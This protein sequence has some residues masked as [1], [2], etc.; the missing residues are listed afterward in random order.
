MGIWGT[1]FVRLVDPDRCN[2][3]FIP[4]T[5]VFVTYWITCTDTQAGLGLHQ[6][7]GSGVNCHLQEMKGLGMVFYQ[8]WGEVAFMLS[9]G[10]EK[11]KS[12]QPQDKERQSENTTM[13]NTGLAKD[14]GR[15]GV[16]TMQLRFGCLSKL[17][18]TGSC[19]ALEKRVAGLGDFSLKGYTG[20]CRYL[21]SSVLFYKKIQQYIYT[22]SGKA[23]Y[24]CVSA[25]VSLAKASQRY[26]LGQKIQPFVRG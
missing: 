5:A 20:F 10:M 15:H 14:I 23:I 11:I 21:T 18:K 2:E 16:E 12:Y 4:R 26:F 1:P 9:E 17:E 19:G 24:I 13:R 8:N 22:V 25:S 7:K 6:G 3:I